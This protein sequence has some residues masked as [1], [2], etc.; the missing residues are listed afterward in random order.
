MGAFLEAKTPEENK[1]IAKETRLQPL[2]GD[3]EELTGEGLAF[4][5]KD[6]NWEVGV[7]ALKIRYRISNVQWQ[8]PLRK[9]DRLIRNKL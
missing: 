6:L 8:S 3:L 1:A 7:K 4:A 9:L 5:S 2:V